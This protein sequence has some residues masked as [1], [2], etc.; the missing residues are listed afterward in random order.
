[1]SVR[2][3]SH[4]VFSIHLH[5]VFVTK[6]RRLVLK[7]QILDRMREILAHVCVKTKCQLIEFN[8]ESDQVHLLINFHPDNNISAFTGSLKSASSRIIRNEFEEQLSKFY[9]NP[10]LWSGSYYVASTGG[11]PIEKIKAYIKSQDSPQE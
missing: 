1:M 6:Y 7:A 4:S 11:A 2:K 10:V 8:G 9:K 5:F 3:G